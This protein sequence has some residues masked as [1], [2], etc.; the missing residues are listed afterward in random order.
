MRR[1]AAL[2]ILTL[3]TSVLFVPAL[4]TAQTSSGRTSP[5]TLDELQ[6]ATYSGIPEIRNPL[7]LVNGRWSGPPATPGASSRPVVELASDFR[8]VGDVDGDGL[9]DS[10]VVL[11]YSSGG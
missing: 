10:V 2:L 7:K 11:T 3:L 5:P 8:I 6:T 1:T 4:V 9:E